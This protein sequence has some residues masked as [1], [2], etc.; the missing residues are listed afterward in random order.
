MNNKKI[1]S[2][3]YQLD[4]YRNSIKKNIG[5][6]KNKYNTNNYRIKG[7]FSYNNSNNSNINNH[8]YKEKCFD[9]SELQMQ[10]PI[11]ND[12]SKISNN[13]KIDNFKSNLFPGL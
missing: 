11:S 3:K 10:L 8:N 1:N 4:F 6:L 7:D 12:R 2:L 9:Y 13:E 5:K